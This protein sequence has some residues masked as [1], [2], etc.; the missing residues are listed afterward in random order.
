MFEDVQSELQIV[1]HD[2]E[3][4]KY[5]TSYE[6]RVNFL[7]GGERWHETIEDDLTKGDLWSRF[8]TYRRFLEWKF[9]E[10]MSKTY[11]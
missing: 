3:S 9:P 5:R 8:H 2:A 1:E 7:Q 4:D 10:E 11:E 6:L